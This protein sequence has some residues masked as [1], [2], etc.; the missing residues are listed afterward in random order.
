MKKLL[1]MSVRLLTLA[2]AFSMLT[3]CTFFADSGDK[4][5]REGL[6]LFLDEDYERAA[7][8]F[9]K[10]VEKGVT[11]YELVDVYKSLGTSYL[12]MDRYEKL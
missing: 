6:L 10:A 4:H 5:Y 3:A 11:K 9:E 8:E 7:E 2:L 1:R 12:E